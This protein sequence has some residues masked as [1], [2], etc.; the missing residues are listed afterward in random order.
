MKEQIE[1]PLV[2][3]KC[4]NCHGDSLVDLWNYKTM[5]K[6]RS[7][8]WVFRVYNVI[9]KNCG[10]I[11]TSPVLNQEYLLKYYR[12]S[13]SAV[14]GQTLDYDIQNRLIVIDKYMSECSNNVYLEIGANLNSKFHSK[15]QERFK[16]LITVEPNPS[17]SNTYY[18]INELKN[19]KAD[20]IAH[21]FVL[22]HVVEI[23]LFF[24]RCKNLLKDD[25]I[26]ICEVPSLDKYEEIIGPLIL[27]E[28]VNHFTPQTLASIAANYGF[29]MLEH[30]TKFCSR[31]FGFV[32]IFKKDKI[33]LDNGINEYEV[34]KKLFQ[35]G[36]R[37]VGIFNDQIKVIRTHIKDQDNKIII[38][39]ANLIT[40]KLLEGIESTNNITIVDVD[41]NKKLFFDGSPEVRLPDEVIEDIDNSNA[42]VIC[43]ATHSIDILAYINKQFGKCYDESAIYIIR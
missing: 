29:K 9:C 12:D 6:T 26:M 37:S 5:T 4:D 22:E 3:R 31:P 42:I 28:H 20:I 30:S 16:Q 33:V 35:S 32:S 18:D 39:V 21:Y 17:A 7:T 41:P 8:Q 34:N 2:K 43:S 24:K 10:F 13:F 1:I 15:L 27:F 40:L 19:I 25:G 11:F 38:W 14:D 23:G 36:L